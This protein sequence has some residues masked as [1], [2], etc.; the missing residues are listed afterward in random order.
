MTTWT[1]PQWRT[2]AAILFP[3]L[4]LAVWALVR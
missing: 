3:F 1:E 4:I 2:L